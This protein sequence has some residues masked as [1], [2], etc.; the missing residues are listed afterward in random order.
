M[1]TL[2][3]MT[4]ACGGASDETTRGGATPSS[5]AAATQATDPCSL[6]TAADAGSALGA[7]VGSP[8]RPKEANI[9]PR[10]S[11]CR[12]VAQRGQGLAVLTVMVRSSDSASEARS[13]FQSAR[14]QF[15]GAETVSG[16]GDE[17][18]WVANQL[19]L[20]RGTVYV[21]ITGD[22]DRA[23]AQSLAHVVLTRLP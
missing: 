23:A 22:V 20:L 18:F 14:E 4:T 2:V 6:V 21:N 9:P 3:C 17:A 15:P 10:L 7:P 13:G 8:E 19:N 1:L 16:I 12:Y 11:T 5:Q